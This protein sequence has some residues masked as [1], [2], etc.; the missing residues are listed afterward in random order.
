MSILATTDSVVVQA[1]PRLRV[2]PSPG[3][4]LDEL[5]AEHGA[6]LRRLVRRR[7]ADPALVDDAVQET[8]LRVCRAS[9]PT[10]PAELRPWLATIAKRTCADVWRS[11]ASDTTA[12][13]PLGERLPAR[14]A[15][16]PG[17]DEHLVAVAERARIG[18]A[19]RHLPPRHRRLLEKQAV[20]GL[21]YEEIAAQEKVSVACVT[22]AL[23]R[24]RAGFRRRYAAAETPAAPAWVALVYRVVDRLRARVHACL[25]PYAVELAAASLTIGMA[26][27]LVGA[28]PSLSES[29]DEVETRPAPAAPVS[30]TAV[31][32]GIVPTPA[33]PAARPARAAAEARP[34][35]P[36]PSPAPAPPSSGPRPMGEV[37]AGSPRVELT[38]TAWTVAFGIEAGAPGGTATVR[39]G[40]SLHCEGGRAMSTVCPVAA[41]VPGAK[42]SR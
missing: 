4:Q 29:R 2:L 38:P 17:S 30:P 11:H 26:A 8:L 23:G 39:L 16:V 20:L 27:V 21:S 37:A 28:T 33:P 7:M 12:L 42:S 36:R 9:P 25:G 24:A 3:P 32:A 41:Q 40:V 31:D 22:S 14:A 13:D 35:A 18:R 5:V 1:P 19:M 34:S 6:W 15:L 10:D